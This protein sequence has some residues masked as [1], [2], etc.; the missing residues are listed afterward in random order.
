[1]VTANRSRFC[2][3]PMYHSLTDDAGTHHVRGKR[4]VISGTYLRFLRQGFCL[5][6][7]L[8]RLWRESREIPRVRTAGIGKQR[9]DEW[10]M[11]L[12]N[13]MKAVWHRAGERR[14]QRLRNARGDLDVTSN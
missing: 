11:R 5:P 12:R 6:P 9:S 7:V 14:A 8:R 10:L 1:M 4:A 3:N 2:R 13:L